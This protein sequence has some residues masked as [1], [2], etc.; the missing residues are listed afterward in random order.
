M[1][2]GEKGRVPCSLQDRG[3]HVRWRAAWATSA[4]HKHCWKKRK[5]WDGVRLKALV[6]SATQLKCQMNSVSAPHRKGNN[7]ATVK[8]PFV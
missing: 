4:Q 6:A 2:R 5:R 1:A 8:V 3:N 7:T